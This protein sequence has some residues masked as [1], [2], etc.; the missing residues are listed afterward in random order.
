M[1][2]DDIFLRIAMLHQQF[3]M[4]RQDDFTCRQIT[5]IRSLLDQAVG[6]VDLSDYD[7]PALLLQWLNELVK[8]R[9]KERAEL[10]G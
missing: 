1:E 3:K 5:Y 8:R 4:A 9:E 7:E 2:Q 10:G 6:S